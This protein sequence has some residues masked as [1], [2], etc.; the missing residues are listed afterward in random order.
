MGKFE[1]FDLLDWCGENAKYGERLSS[2]TRLL[3]P[4]SPN[5][6]SWTFTNLVFTRTFSVWGLNGSD[7]SR[8]RIIIKPSLGRT[9]YIRLGPSLSTGLKGFG[10]STR[11][12]PVY[13]DRLHFGSFT[14][15]MDKLVFIH[16]KKYKLVPPLNFKLN[17]HVVC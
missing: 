7:L 14:E 2:Y 5:Q 6:C 16:F 1:G 15:E 3:A 12:A 17:D 9:G 8:L 13:R 4:P 10:K 11:K